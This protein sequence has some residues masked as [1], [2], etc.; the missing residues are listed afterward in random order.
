MPTLILVRHGQSQWN[1]ENRFTGWWDVDLT[2]K[3]VAEAKAAGAL[4]AEKNVLPTRA[5]TSVQTAR[6]PHAAPR[7]RGLRPAVDPRGKGLAPQRTALWRA[8]RARQ[9]RDRREARRGT[10]ARMAPQL[11][12]PAA[13][14]IERWRQATI[15]RAMRAMPGHRLFPTTES[16]A[17]TIARVLP[18]WQRDDHAGAGERGDGDRLGA[19]QFAARAGQA[20]VG[21]FGRGD[22]RAGD[23]HR[24]ADRLPVRRGDARRA[25]AI[26]SRMPDAMAGPDSNAG[27]AEGRHRHGQPVGLGDHE[28]TPPRCSSELGVAHEAR[29]VSAH[30]TPDRLHAFGKGA[31]GEGFSVIVAGA[32]GAAHLPGMIAALT[33]LPV[34][35]VPVRSRAL[36]GLD[37]PPL[38]RPDARRRA[39]G[40][41]RDRRGGRDATRACSPPRSWHSRTRRWRDGWPTGRAA[42]T[43]SVAERPS[44]D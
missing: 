25:S 15:W 43:A 19:R 6:D 36:S 40:D 22:H 16:L 28:A 5:F 34:L 29:I 14:E 4:L 17:L 1:L 9:G 20:P 30:R 10:G 31:E 37:S 21:H 41:A 24:P 11:R 3:G 8:D 27:R 35:G 7:A 33:A 42:Q 12:Y 26:I 39:C 32:G 44:D 2:D 13:S 18:Y 23:S 38:D